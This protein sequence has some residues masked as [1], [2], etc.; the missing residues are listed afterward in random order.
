[1]ITILSADSLRILS[2]A[3][4]AQFFEHMVR[5]QTHTMMPREE[6]I[7]QRNRSSASPEQPCH[8]LKQK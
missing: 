3:P 5:A 7:E 4:R 2:R 1:M 8:Y 6:I